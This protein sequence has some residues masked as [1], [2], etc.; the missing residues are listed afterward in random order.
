MAS[1]ERS[2]SFWAMA[3]RS[4]VGAAERKS[5]VVPDPAQATAAIAAR[6]G[7]VRVG[8]MVGVPPKRLVG[9]HLGREAG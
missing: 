8:F 3:R 7:S 5:W 4:Y 2:L 1:G 6:R 9:R